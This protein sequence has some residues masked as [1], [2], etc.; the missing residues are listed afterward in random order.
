[1]GGAEGAGYDRQRKNNGVVPR[2]HGLLDL[3]YE[4]CTALFQGGQASDFG[5][6]ERPQF[7]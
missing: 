5:H 1:M 3:L 4:G 2:C 6:R 7:T